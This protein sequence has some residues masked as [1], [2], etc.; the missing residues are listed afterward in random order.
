VYFQDLLQPEIPSRLKI[1]MK[2]VYFGTEIVRL[3][4]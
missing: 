1:E 3:D 4:D 2:L